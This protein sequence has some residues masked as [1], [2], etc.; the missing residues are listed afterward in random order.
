MG[1]NPWWQPSEADLGWDEP[2][3][4]VITLA[5]DYGA[6]LPLWGD[7]WGNQPGRGP[8]RRRTRRA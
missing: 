7:G 5:P 1:E 4:E 3:P 2:P 6:E 8:G